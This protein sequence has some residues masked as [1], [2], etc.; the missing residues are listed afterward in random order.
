MK[1][2]K[3]SPQVQKRMKELILQGKTSK[4]VAEIIGCTKKTVYN[5]TKD[6]RWQVKHPTQEETP[7]QAEE[8]TG[9][10]TPYKQD[11]YRISRY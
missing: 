3:T 4:E 11:R 10:Q 9:F 6:E 5:Y 8:T 7:P 1:K 2:R